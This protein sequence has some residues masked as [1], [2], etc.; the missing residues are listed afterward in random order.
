MLNVDLSEICDLTEEHCRT[1]R[2][3][4]V[5]EFQRDGKHLYYINAHHVSGT[6]NPTRT[7]VRQAI[8]RF[9]PNLVIVERLETGTEFVKFVNEESASDFKRGGEAEYAAHLAMQ[10]NIPFK[11]AEPSDKDLTAGM[12]ELGYSAKDVM[13]FYLL[14]S[15]PVWRNQGVLDQ[16]SFGER[17]AGHLEY[18]QRRAGVPETEMLSFQGFMG[19]FEKHNTTGKTLLK[20]D[21]NDIHP[22]ISSDANYFQKLH[23]NLDPIRERHIDTVIAKSFTEH[24]RVLVV[25]GDGHLVKSQFVFQKMFG[26]PGRTLQL[27]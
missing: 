24:D 21:N 17:A 4:A 10:H 25:Y 6:D 16:S 23:H 9:N 12:K 18:W 11:G 20:I 19:W 7:T 8:T 3:V 2:P 14:R 15:I 13:A 5:T 26:E 1:F 22:T 27:T